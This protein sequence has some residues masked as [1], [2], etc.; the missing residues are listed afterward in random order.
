MA[1]ISRAVEII[2]GV[3]DNTSGALDS[4]GSSIGSLGSKVEATTQP[5]A[6]L[7]AGLLKIEAAAIAMGGA[8]VGYSIASAVEA[9]S[10]FADLNKVLGDGETDL[11]AYKTRIREIG[12]EFGASVP[13]VT[14]AAAN[15]KQAGFDI[16][17]VLGPDGLVVTALTATKIADQELGDATDTII[18]QL[19]G[20][21]QAP[22]EAIIN[23]DKLNAVTNKYAT[24]VPELSEALK[25]LAPIASATNIPFEDMLGIVTPVVEVWRDGTKSANALKVG[26]TA[27][28]T[29]TGRASTE[30]ERLGVTT[31]DAN[32]ELLPGVDIIRQVQEKF[33]GMTKEQ[34]LASAAMIAGGSN[35]N[36]LVLAFR[37]L[38]YTSAI[39][40]TALAGVG[41]S[42]KN[43]LAIRLDTAV[44]TIDRFKASLGILATAIGD[45]LLPTFTGATEGAQTFVEALV[46][47]VE[48]GGFDTL[49]EPLSKLFDEAGVK[50]KDIAAILPGVIAELDFSGLVGSFE[51]LGGALTGIF[52]GLDLTDPKDLKVVLQGIVDTG[53]SLNRVVGGIITKFA[54]FTR[55][56]ILPAIDSFNKL[57]AST[58][59]TTGEWLGF[60]TIV[61]EL[62]GALTAIGNVF[63]LLS[64][65][66]AVKFVK[67][68][69]GTG[70]ATEAVGLFSGSLG[71]LLL[72]LSGPAGAIAVMGAA[73]Y[74]IGD[75]IAKT[76]GL[77][78]GFSIWV[79]DLIDGIKGTD[80]V[81][82]ESGASLEK[83]RGELDALREKFGITGSAAQGFSTD[84]EST[85][86][87]VE[88]VQEPMA[89][90]VEEINRLNP[91]MSEGESNASALEQQMLKMGLAIDGT[92]DGLE[93]TATAA[94]DTAVKTGELSIAIRDANGKIIGYEDSLTGIKTKYEESSEAAEKATQET[95]TF[96]IKMEE[97]ASN[98]RI[99]TIEATVSLNIAQLEADSKEAIALIDAMS[100]ALSSSSELL[101]SLFGN[102]GDL[103]GLDK[104]LIERVIR[105]T[106]ED[107]KRAAQ[108][109]HDYSKAQLE[110]LQAKTEALQR[111]DGLITI[112]A[113]GLEPELEAFMWKII[114]RI[115]IQ[116]S[117]LESD[118]LL[119]LPTP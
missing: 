94:G 49:L 22:S 113:D 99:K 96:R 76:T 112:K 20:F 17:D 58:K 105:S 47:S 90:T 104:V 83:Y 84:M 86:T 103:E 89:L 37:D 54:E 40:E 68:L 6:D 114:E 31:R 24:D 117:I 55:D 115:Q 61:N 87:A 107:R 70:S 75:F 56:A 111:G 109:L 59:S 82:T 7:T 71:K 23:L 101:G 62:S 4:I 13:T 51:D 2:F 28:A 92:K 9:Q 106:E 15:F 88:K 65:V 42:A 36:A 53:E 63:D 29:D 93:G 26:L 60:G 10:T 108:D 52:G 118:F 119:G 18:S 3:V 97:L 74:A 98:E 81:A 27:M 69:V 12:L 43:E 41:N 11:D 5:I 39:T 100:E 32:G 16:D 66:I 14:E 1:D 44:V 35:A 91:A 48:Q 102:L 8:V 78:E 77:D 45:Q 50:L 25:I 38:N 19:R 79:N 21:G 110:A 30:M 67:S 73:G 72:G 116:A 64:A 46:R 80:S 34:Q 85:G 33:Q 57:D 95:E